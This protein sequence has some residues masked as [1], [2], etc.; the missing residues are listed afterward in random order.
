MIFIRKL[1]SH[2]HLCFITFVRIRILLIDPLGPFRL[3][4][5]QSSRSR[6]NLPNRNQDVRAH[7]VRN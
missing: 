3:Y 4:F 1:P 5:K 2:F 7:H 6:F